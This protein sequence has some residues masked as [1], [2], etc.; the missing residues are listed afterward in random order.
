MP[1]S[2]LVDQP[3]E[4]AVEIVRLVQDVHRAAAQ[5]VGRANHQ[6]EADRG[7][8]PLRLRRRY[9]GPVG[10][11]PQ[12]QAVQQRLEPLPVLGEVDGVGRGTEDGDAGGGQGARELQRGLTAELDDDAEQ[13]TVLLFGADQFDHVLFGERL[14]IEPVGG[15]VVGRH[16][17]G[18]AVDH[19]R[20][21][22]RSLQ[23][24]GGMDAA[25]VELDA[26]T[27]AV[28]DRRRG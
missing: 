6:R 23:G 13:S 27:D 4:V 10:R 19:D 20:F 5:D 28:R 16:G 24:V 7:R 26:L 15:I 12:S 11:L 3:L 22:A 25:V 17:L 9:G 8:H 18:I 14:E 1:A 21:V 2:R